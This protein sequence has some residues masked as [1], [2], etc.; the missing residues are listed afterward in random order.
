MR[1][2]IV[3]WLVVF[4]LVTAVVGACGAEEWRNFIYTGD[5]TSACATGTT[6]W[7]GTKGGIVA[8]DNESGALMHYTRADGLVRPNIWHLATD[9][10]GSVWAATQHGLARFG[11]GG[12]M[13]FPSFVH[14]VQEG[15]V[16]WGFAIDQD[17][18]KWL[19]TGDGAL[20]F[21]GQTWRTFDPSNSPLL[22]KGAI[23]TYPISRISRTTLHNIL[24]LPWRRSSEAEQTA[25]NRWVTGSSPVAATKQ[26]GVTTGRRSVASFREY[27]GS[28]LTSSVAV[29]APAP[30]PKR[31][32]CGG[33]HSTDRKQKHDTDGTS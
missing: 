4:T 31:R 32:L 14:G 3:L 19:A 12:F 26:N 7:V 33:A 6:I 21:D 13:C 15:C 16:P 29:S 28:R 20:S 10:D 2:R 24:W 22:T 18:V 11:G 8:L 25:Y 17:G 27:V 30:V 1:H 23:Q 5:I 9:I